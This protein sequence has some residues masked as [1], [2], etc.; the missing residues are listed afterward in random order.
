MPAIWGHTVKNNGGGFFGF[1]FFNPHQ[2][3]KERNI[4]VRDIDQLPSRMCPSQGPNLQPAY[5]LLP[6]IEAVTFWSMGQRSNSLSHI[7]QGSGGGFYS[8]TRI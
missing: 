2:G 7:G 6:G 4:D 5:V 8:N 1:F 3:E